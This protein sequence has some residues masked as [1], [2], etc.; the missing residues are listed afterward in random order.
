MTNTLASFIQ[1]IISRDARLIGRRL[2]SWVAGAV[3]VAAL[4]CQLGTPALFEPDEGR[5]AEK[6]REILVLNDWVTPHEN[7][8]PVLDKPIFYYWLIAAAYAVFGI[9]EW[10][11]RLPSALAALGSIVLAYHF[12]RSF[13]RWPAL[14]SALVLLTS[15]EFFVLAR[16]TIF[17]MTLSFFLMLALCAFYHATHADTAASR[18]GWSAAMYAAL[19]AATLI[20]GLIG[21][22]I[23]GMVFFVYLV[24][25]KQWSLLRRI[26]LLPGTVL[27]LAV[28]LPWYWLAEQRNP[29]Y[30]QYFFM[31]EHFGRFFTNEFERGEP[32][33]YFIVVVAVGFL[34]WTLLLPF[35][36]R[37]VGREWLENRYPDG[38]LYLLLC[39]ILPFLFFSISKSK[40]PHYILPIFAPLAML[41]GLALARVF[42]DGPARLQRLLRFT[43]WIQ[44]CLALFFLAGWFF[45]ALAPQQIRSALSS[46][47]ASIWSY[48]AVVV[49]MLASFAKRTAVPRSQPRL[50][51][52]QSSGLCVLLALAVQMMALIAPQRSAK[53]IAAAVLAGLPDTAQVVM[54]DTYLAGLPFYL[55]SERPLWLITKE[56]RKR[57][58]IGNYYVVGKHADP[59]TPWGQAILDFDEFESIWHRTERPFRIIVKEKNLPRMTEDLGIAP[60]RLAAVDEYL[61][62]AK[63]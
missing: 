43:W 53:P 23:P 22:V 50:Y 31:E 26:Y 12:M 6:A 54:Y 4:F 55:H 8:H 28:V 14:W 5:N 52:L 20:K 9:S 59:M 41:T 49:L 46:M 17:D 18:R 39:A 36:A 29:G 15:I 62:L 19:G 21:V 33:Y 45:P 1:Q 2:G 11:A 60:P 56:R 30:L 25:T 42:E 34:P 13:G 37:V 44:I 32:W 48:A 63:P 58:F 7:F 27:F 57:S 38:I 61:V 35:V 51:V 24:A 3:T 47:T 16:V 40:L 10:S